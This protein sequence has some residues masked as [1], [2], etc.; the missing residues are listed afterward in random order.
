M[1]NAYLNTIVSVYIGTYHLSKSMKHL[2]QYV[3]TGSNFSSSTHCEEWLAFKK[4]NTFRKP[5]CWWNNLH[6]VEKCIN[7]Y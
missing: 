4:H 3:N 1:P 2:D 6:Y 7:K 5:D